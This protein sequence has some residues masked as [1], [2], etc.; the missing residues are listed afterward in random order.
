MTVVFRMGFYASNATE[1]R[2]G[3]FFVRERG[4]WGT[5]EFSPDAGTLARSER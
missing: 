4:D 5:N 2:Y 3:L 1:R